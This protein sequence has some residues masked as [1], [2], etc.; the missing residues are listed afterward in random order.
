MRNCAAGKASMGL[1][2]LQSFFEEKELA[3]DQEPRACGEGNLVHMI[4]EVGN[5]SH[6]GNCLSRWSTNEAWYKAVCDKMSIGQKV[7]DPGR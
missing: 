1:I 4:I 3:R 7:S 5:V 6:R 2:D